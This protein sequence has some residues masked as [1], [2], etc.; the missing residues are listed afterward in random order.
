MIHQVERAVGDPGRQVGWTLH[1]ARQR[2]GHGHRRH[3]GVKGRLPQ[4]RKLV[5]QPGVRRLVGLVVEHHEHALAVREHL[6]EGRPG[7]QREAGGGGGS[8]RRHERVRHQPARFNVRRIHAGGRVVSVAQQDCDKVLRVC[9]DPCA[10]L[11]QPAFN[12]PRVQQLARG[13]AKVRPGPVILGREVHLC[14]HEPDA[15]IE[16]LRH[17]EVLV[18]R[19]VVA[20]H[21]RRV[22]GADQGDVAVLARAEFGIAIADCGVGQRNGGGHVG[23]SIRAVGV[24]HDL[25]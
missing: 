17:L 14:L 9:V 19:E 25:A 5:E 11:G 22:V 23:R 4:V 3:H 18:G 2:L 24:L 8:G 15:V 20:L 12:G 10:H 6:A 21:K 16:L 7:V 1:G 13:M